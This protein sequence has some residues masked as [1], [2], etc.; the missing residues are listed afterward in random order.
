MRSFPK[1]YRRR[2]QA[3]AVFFFLFGGIE[4]HHKLDRVLQLEI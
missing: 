1:T 2:F 4:Y 3:E